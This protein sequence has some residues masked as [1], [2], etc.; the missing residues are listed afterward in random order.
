MPC[1]SLQWIE[2]EIWILMYS[3]ETKKLSRNIAGGHNMYEPPIWDKIWPD[4]ESREDE[5]YYK[6]HPEEWEEDQKKLHQSTS[7]D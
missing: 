7:N 5:E 6:E 3:M 1:G 4:K 2:K